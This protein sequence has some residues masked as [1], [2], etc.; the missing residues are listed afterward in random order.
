[1]AKSP[2]HKFGQIIGKFVE[3]AFAARLQ[4]FCN[5]NGLYLDKNGIR[6]GRKGKKLSWSDNYGN[7]HDLDFVIE[8]GGTNEALGVPVAF[9]ESA[10]R[11]Y[12]K[13]SRNKAQEIQG[14]ILPL[15][16]KYKIN[17]PF[18]GVMLAGRFTDGALNQ[19]RSLGFEILYFPYE[20]IIDSFADFGFDISFGENTTENE[21]DAMIELVNQMDNLNLNLVADRIFSRNSTACDNFFSRLSVS[22][23]RKIASVR[24]LPLHGTEILRPTILDAINY[25]RKSTAEI[26]NLPFIRYELVVRFTNGDKAE[27]N[28]GTKRDAINFLEAIQRIDDMEIN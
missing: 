8:K 4:L 12:T 11:V 2:S 27:G 19:L 22:V 26:P 14:A 15:L 23:K 25:I 20:T 10:W 17:S 9:I 21:F 1:M 18:L 13:H 6:I 3:D 24:I 5:D 7:K 16:E 28:F